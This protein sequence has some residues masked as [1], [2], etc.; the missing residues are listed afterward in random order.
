MQPSALHNKFLY[1]NSSFLNDF[2]KK[3]M[4]V[5]IYKNLRGM[6]WLNFSSTKSGTIFYG[7][8]QLAESAF[9]LNT[10]KQAYSQV[11]KTFSFMLDAAMALGMGEVHHQMNKTFSDVVE[12]FLSRHTSWEQNCWWRVKRLVK[13]EMKLCLQAVDNG[14]ASWKLEIDTYCSRK[15]E[16]TVSRE[17]TFSFLGLLNTVD[18][19]SQQQLYVPLY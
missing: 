11:T 7:F 8:M 10:L 5:A 14:M 18:K 9:T 13:N 2:L 12:S 16:E 4:P 6:T 3:G 15:E 19:C 17:A 1:V